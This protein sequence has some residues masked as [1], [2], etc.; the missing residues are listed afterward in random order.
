MFPLIMIGWTIIGLLVLN[1]S[2]VRTWIGAGIGAAILSIAL[3]LVTTQTVR[4]GIAVAPFVAIA[5]AYGFHRLWR[6]G[7]ASK[8]TI[9][10]LMAW[11]GVFWYSELWHRIMVYLHD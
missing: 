7:Y 6:F 11:Y 10:M 9:V 5:C 8:I 1:P 4:W 3:L 2:L